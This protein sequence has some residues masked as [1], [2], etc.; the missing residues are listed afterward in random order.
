MLR[1][2]A[3]RIRR[4][5]LFLNQ[6]GNNGDQ[7]QFDRTV[8]E[9]SQRLRNAEADVLRDLPGVNRARA[10]PVRA[11]VVNDAADG[12]QV[13]LGMAIQAIRTGC[14]LLARSVS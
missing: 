2:S 10:P 3:D 6:V 14:E 12:Y 8:T 13:Q 11:P 4:Y 9:F 7:D 1:H 5:A